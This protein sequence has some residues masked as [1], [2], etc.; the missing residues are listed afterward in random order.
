MD[1]AGDRP[2]QEQELIRGG[3]YA[4]VTWLTAC[5]IS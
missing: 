2:N 4:I 1:G 3:C 5:W